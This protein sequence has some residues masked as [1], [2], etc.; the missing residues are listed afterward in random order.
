MDGETA[1]GVGAGEDGGVG[2]G[3]GVGAGAD[4]G[5]CGAVSCARLG[6][7]WSRSCALRPRNPE[8]LEFEPGEAREVVA[9]GGLTGE[10]ADSIVADGVAPDGFTGETPARTAADGAGEAAAM[11]PVVAIWEDVV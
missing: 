3:A 8:G 9:A 2:V 5:A 10:A 4:A 7:S 11:S 6:I 1:G